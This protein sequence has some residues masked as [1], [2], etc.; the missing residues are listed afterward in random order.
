MAENVTPFWD[1]VFGN[2]SPY[3]RK[4]LKRLALVLTI[5][6]AIA[7]LN[8]INNKVDNPLHILYGKDK[9]LLVAN[10]R[11][12]LRAI[13][14][15]ITSSALDLSQP[16]WVGWIPGV[17][18]QGSLEEYLSRAFHVVPRG[19]TYLTDR[20]WTRRNVQVHFVARAYDPNTNSYSDMVPLEEADLTYGGIVGIPNLPREGE[21]LTT[22]IGAIE[23]NLYWQALIT[24]FNQVLPDDMNKLEGLDV[25]FFP[26]VS[27][28]AEFPN[29]LIGQ[30]SQAAKQQYPDFPGTQGALIGRQYFHYVVDANCPGYQPFQFINADQPNLEGL[31]CL[32]Q[33]GGT[34]VVG[35]L[36]PPKGFLELIGF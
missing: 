23:Q 9:R 14:Q 3:V 17:P 4:F 29:E 7:V 28:G 6:G 2:L 12:L 24:A 22:V 1:L 20:S 25:V 13:Y 16:G 35:A 11:G 31:A 33:E 8:F 27:Q 15:K 5:G 19:S 36:N 21:M 30:I 18:G 26:F 10:N 32:C 34:A